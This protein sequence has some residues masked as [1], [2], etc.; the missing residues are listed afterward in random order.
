[1]PVGKESVSRTDLTRSATQ[2]ELSETPNDRPREYQTE[3]CAP[4][5]SRTRT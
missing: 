5:D 3:T 4:H 1:M 2:R